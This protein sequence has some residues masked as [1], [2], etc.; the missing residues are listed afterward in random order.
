MSWKNSKNFDFLAHC[1]TLFL[2]LIVSGCAGKQWTTPLEGDRF[3]EVSQLVDSLNH[4]YQACGQSLDGDL[5]LF[6]SDPLEKKALSGYLRFSTPGSYKFVVTNPFGQTLLAIAGNQKSYQAIYVPEKQYMAGS[7]RSFGVRHNLPAE[8][9]NGNWGEWITARNQRP[10]NTIKAIHED[11]KGRG[12]WISFSHDKSEP[13]G[14]SHL[15]L[16]PVSNLPLSRILENGAGKMVAEVT[17]GD[18]IQQG[19]CRQPQ[20]I[21][22]TGLDYGTDVRLKLSDVR[23]TSEANQFTLPIPPGYIQQLLP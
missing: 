23:L 9:L 3:N 20:E 2:A 5:A 8:I 18:W 22:I 12:L 4:A 19:E 16:E 13:A 7:M 11:K 1:L 14:M 15:L 17:Y 21:I 6:Y 10:S